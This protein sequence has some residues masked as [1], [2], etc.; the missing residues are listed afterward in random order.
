MNLEKIKTTKDINFLIKIAEKGN[1]HQCL[2]IFENKQVDFEGHP[3]FID[4]HRKTLQKEIVFFI[5]TAN[6]KTCEKTLILIAKYFK[7]LRYLL[8]LNQEMPASVLLFLA[9]DSYCEQGLASNKNTPKEALDILA[10]NKVNFYELEESYKIW[11]QVVRN[12]NVSVKTL[13]FLLNEYPDFFYYHGMP[14]KLPPC[15]RFLLEEKQSLR[16]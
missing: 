8:C 11:R 16:I 7:N 4:T 6:E 5:K 12:K 10:R 14:S 9:K 3:H 15:L 13:L 1:L 2:T